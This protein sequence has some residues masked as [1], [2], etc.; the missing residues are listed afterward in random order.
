MTYDLTRD[1]VAARVA[2]LRLA[3]ASCRTDGCTC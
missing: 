2:E 1:L 3:A